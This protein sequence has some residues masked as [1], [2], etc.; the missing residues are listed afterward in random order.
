MRGFYFETI[1]ANFSMRSF[2]FTVFMSVLILSGSN[3]LA[4]N[5]CSSGSCTVTQTSYPTYSQQQSYAPMYSAGTSYAQP[6]YSQPVYSQPVYSQP[7][8]QQAYA[9]PAYSQPVYSSNQTYYSG[10]S[11]SAPVYSN[12]TTTSYNVVSNAQ[13]IYSSPSYTTAYPTTS[14]PTST[15]TSS[16]SNYSTPTYSNAS[17]GT[18]ASYRSAAAP[19]TSM[20][21]YTTTANNRQVSGLAQ[22]KASRMARMNLRGHLG[23]GFGGAQYEGVGWSNVSPQAAIERCCYWGQRSPA[24]IGVSKGN[25][26]C[27][28]ACVLYN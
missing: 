17:T 20:P 10:A 21:S 25:D 5:C 27:W 2:T 15:Y 7:V 3:G 24:Q 18:F 26:G 16:S 8:Y 4:Q 11:Y 23:G 19:T 13:P 28:Y 1:E 9:Q 14:I 12:S 22:S 6:V